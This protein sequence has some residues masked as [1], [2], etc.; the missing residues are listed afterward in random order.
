MRALYLPQFSY[1]KPYL[2]IDPFFEEANTTKKM[3]CVTAMIRSKYPR[4][5]E[6]IA[7]WLRIADFQTTFD[8]LK[9]L[10]SYLR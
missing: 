8:I 6:F 7:D 9:M 5:D 4:T 1:F 10:R 2:A 3:Q